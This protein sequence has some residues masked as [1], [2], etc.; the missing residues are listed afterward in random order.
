VIDSRITDDRL[1]GNDDPFTGFV[2]PHDAEVFGLR[3]LLFVLAHLL[4]HNVA[5]DKSLE[6]VEPSKMGITIPRGLF[7]EP[8][9]MKGPAWRIRFCRDREVGSKKRR[10]VVRAVSAVGQHPFSRI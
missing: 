1:I 2:V 4:F 6:P 8:F 9:Q 10:R 5:L 7:W 3:R